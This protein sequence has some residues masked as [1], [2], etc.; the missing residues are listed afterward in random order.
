MSA[1]ATAA[2]YLY[3]SGRLRADGC[4]RR[5]YDNELQ[6]LLNAPPPSRDKN[7]PRVRAQ[8]CRECVG[9]WHLYTSY[10]KP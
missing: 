4:Q 5:K 9:K 7:G 3:A 8:A 6:A 10:R 2:G 1:A